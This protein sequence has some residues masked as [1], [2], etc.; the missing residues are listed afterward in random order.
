MSL[1][2]YSD[3][4]DESD[5]FIETSNPDPS[6]GSKRKRMGDDGERTKPLPPLPDT[7]HNVYAS[8]ARIGTSDDPSLHGGRQRQVPHIEGNWPTHVYIECKHLPSLQS[9]FRMY[10]GVWGNTHAYEGFRR[11]EKRFGCKVFSARYGRPT[12]SGAQARHHYKVCYRVIWVRNCRCISACR[13]PSSCRPIS[14][15]HSWT[16]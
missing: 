11:Q 16:R 13:N 6:P 5:A 3:S 15:G 14:A 7:F 4:G 1:V 8:T 2:D 9:F 10:K 12:L